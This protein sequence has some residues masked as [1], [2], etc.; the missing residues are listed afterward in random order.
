M[1]F[2]NAQETRKVRG[3]LASDMLGI[4]ANHLSSV[5]CFYTAV[6]P[7]ITPATGGPPSL[8][9]YLSLRSKFFGLNNPTKY[10]A[11]KSK[12]LRIAWP[13]LWTMIL[14]QLEDG[15]AR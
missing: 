3:I 6:N 7:A 13:K 5:N 8:D 4:L 11:A 12:R 9:K 2:L 1:H 14:P 10:L 15:G